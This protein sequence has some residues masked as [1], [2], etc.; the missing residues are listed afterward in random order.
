MKSGTWRGVWTAVA[1]GALLLAACGGPSIDVIPPDR[2]PNDA[3]QGAAVPMPVGE[4]VTD[5]LNIDAGDHTDW[6]SLQLDRIGELEL[7]LRVY[8]NKHAGHLQ[9]VNPHKTVVLS[10]DLAP[11]QEAYYVQIPVQQPGL[12]L[13]GISLRGGVVSYEML[14][15]WR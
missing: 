1:L 7:R 4:P 11:G 2:A 14:A 13:V 6:K 10:Q 8:R 5:T 12:W 3:W 9:V 15:E